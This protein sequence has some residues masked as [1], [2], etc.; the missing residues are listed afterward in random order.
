MSESSFN[1][2]ASSYDAANALTLASAAEAAYAEP[3]ELD[4]KVEELGFRKTDFFDNDSTQGF[5]AVS[6]EAILLAFRGTQTEEIK[7]ILADLKVRMVEGPAGRIHRGFNAALAAVWNDVKTRVAELHDEKP[8]PIWVT[9]HS[10][11][12]ALATLAC[13]RLEMEEKRPVQGLYLYGSPRVGDKVFAREYDRICKAKTFRFVNN[14]DAV[15]RV[16]V[17]LKLFPYKH[18]GTLEYIDVKGRLRPTI[19][20]W[21]RLLDRLR[22]RVRDLGKLGTDGMKDHGIARYVNWL[23]QHFQ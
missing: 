17:P 23:K 2:K 18:V 11:G 1:P 21:R 7:D 22:G 9:G 6:D 16:P 13:A 10:L 19:S 8:R 15:T 12:A 4:A 5:L 14:N 20:W 3:D